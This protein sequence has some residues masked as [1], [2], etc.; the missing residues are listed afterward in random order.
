VAPHRRYPDP[1][2]QLRLLAI[3]ARREGVDFD[4]FWQRAVRPG[5]PPVLANESPSADVVR[6]PTDREDRAQFLKAL[7][8]TEHAWRCAYEGLPAPRA[9]RAVESLYEA[10][11]TDDGVGLLMAA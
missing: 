9:I 1:L 4:A 8:A 3:E 6:W 10:L 7:E 2:T 11:A 5:L